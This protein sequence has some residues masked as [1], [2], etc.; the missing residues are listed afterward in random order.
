METQIKEEENEPSL[1]FET[2]GDNL[3]SL[4][5]IEKYDK[6]LHN[7][8]HDSEAD[9]DGDFLPNETLLRDEYARLRRKTNNF[10][11]AKCQSS[12]SPEKRSKYKGMDFNSSDI[13]DVDGNTDLRNG[14]NKD[15]KSSLA[16]LDEL[17]GK[18]NEV[19]KHESNWRNILCT[20]EEIDNISSRYGQLL[21]FIYKKSI[22][23]F[24]KS[25]GSKDSD[26]QEPDVDVN[27]DIDEDR[28]KD[29]E[30]NLSNR[31]NQDFVVLGK[32]IESVHKVRDKYFEVEQE[33][34]EQIEQLE[35]VERYKMES[36]G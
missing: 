32:K 12:S 30:N 24:E 23:S 9:S 34:R 8:N 27:N 19:R 3:G 22:S 1:C 10:M 2:S 36:G 14:L 13:V 31:Q 15:E 20:E 4:T 33:V 6:F 11:R 25:N 17:I 18:L 7:E 29:D 26:S 35:L 28:D 21:D 16:S 5:L